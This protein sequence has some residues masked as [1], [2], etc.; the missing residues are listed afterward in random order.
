MTTFA[1]LNLIEP[2]QRSLA[3][4]NYQFPTPIQAQTIPVALEGRDILGCAQTGTGKTAAFALPILDFIAQEQIP[5]RSNSPIAL[6]LAP[7]RELAIQIRRSFDEY[8][9]YL[10][11]RTALVFG[12]VGQGVQ[13][14]ELKRGPHILVATPGR[15]IDLMDQGFV[16][17]D[18]LEVFVLD[19]AD[20]M[21]DMGFMP[22]LKKIIAKLPEDRQSLFFSATLPDSIIKL[23]EQ[24]LFQPVKVNV[25]PE[26][27][28]V[29][30]IDQQV[31]LV[32]K[33]GKQSLLHQI[34]RDPKVVRAIVFTRTKRGANLVSEKLRKGGI[35]SAAI[36]GNKSQRAR[37]MALES[38]KSSDIRVLVAT[39][40]AA[41]GIDI[42]GV[43]HVINFDIPN[44]PES[45]VHRIGRTG[46]AG[47]SGMAISFCSSAER[48][49]LRTIQELIGKQI[50]LAVNQPQP[51]ED[52]Q[53]TRRISPTVNAKPNLA[54]RPRRKSPAAK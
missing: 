21:L 5:A 16:R 46:R 38:F 11:L 36:H 49:D 52:T 17:L 25:T 50:P 22:A 32:E 2:L 30:S 28:S 9:Q 14:R 6:V 48:G 1:Q 31:M 20:R 35:A 7:T 8:G 45:Y 26:S 12:G 3:E 27:N 29:K 51:L 44:E 54:K 10:K 15:L 39:D 18:D 42:D 37:Q 23:S 53:R 19:E 34:L 33:N 43:S 40:L 4:L 24:L 47:A 13:V 41:R